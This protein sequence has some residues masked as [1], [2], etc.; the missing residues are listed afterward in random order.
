MARCAGNCAADVNTVSEP[1]NAERHSCA[2]GPKRRLHGN[3]T[4]RAW[5]R[6]G[7]EQ[8]SLVMDVG[9]PELNGVEAIREALTSLDG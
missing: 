2:V 8:F 9:M 4:P 3:A 6:S 7:S 1:I 5:I